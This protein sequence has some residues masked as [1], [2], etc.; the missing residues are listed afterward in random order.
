M[1]AGG[2]LALLRF[3]PHEV[4]TQRKVARRQL[5]REGAQQRAPALGLLMRQQLCQQPPQLRH[6][7]LRIHQHLHAPR[8]VQGG[9]G[10]QCNVP[11]KLLLVTCRRQAPLNTLARVV[12]VVASMAVCPISNLPAQVLHN[13]SCSA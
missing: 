12:G 2:D 8:H 1:R 3:L 11:A 9:P 5:R 6:G 4:C 7:Q 13:T 10:T